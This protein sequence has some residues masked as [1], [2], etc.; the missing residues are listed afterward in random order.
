M[1][2]AALMLTGVSY[3]MWSQAVDIDATAGMGTIAT[4]MTGGSAS[5]NV[6]WVG[7]S[8]TATSPSVALSLATVAAGSYTEDF[9]LAN[10]GTIPVKI[11]GITPAS[12][13]AGLPA[14]STVTVTGIAVGDQLDPGQSESGQVNVD[15]TAGV[16]DASFTVGVTVSPWN[17]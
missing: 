14:G 8:G 15:L 16:A 9:T 3:G 2:L 7:P 13:P 1:L 5:A 10:N 11:T 4:Q 12:T 17:Q 6:T